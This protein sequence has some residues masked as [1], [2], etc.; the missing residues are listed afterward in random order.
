MMLD[1]NSQFINNDDVRLEDNF[2]KITM[3]KDW[4]RKFLNSDDER[5]EQTIFK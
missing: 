1:W 2:F 4:N 3:M 5:L